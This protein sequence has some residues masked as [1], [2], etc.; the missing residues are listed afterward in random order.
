MKTVKSSNYFFLLVQFAAIAVLAGRAWQHWFWDA[1]F[2]ALLWDEAWMSDWVERFSDYSWEEYITSGAVDEGIQSLIRAM[3][4]LY[5]LGALA[6]LYIRRLPRFLGSILPIAS[7]GLILLAALY[8]KEK[9]FSLGQFLEYT[10]QFSS[11]VFL[12]LLVYRPEW[13]Q[14]L[15]FWMKLAIALTFICHGL[16]A[17][18]Y[19]PRPGSF[20]QMTIDILGVGEETAF[21]FLTLAGLLDFVVA[22]LIFFPRRIAQWALLYAFAWGLATATARLWANFYW[23]LPLESLHQW[24][25]E[26]VMRLPHALIPLALWWEQR[27]E[28]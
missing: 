11:P 4:I 15:L 22:L 20:V 7:A 14:R 9:F 27:S 23:D 13:K 26:V 8:C 12:Y 17:V 10:L 18:N 24:T 16:Y 19:Y 25:H 1:P 2:R 28:G 5:L 6:A 3:G 21:G